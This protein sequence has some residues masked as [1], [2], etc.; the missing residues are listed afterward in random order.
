MLKV[1]SA[2]SLGLI[3]IRPTPLGLIKGGGVKE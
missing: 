3:E 2:N 1:A